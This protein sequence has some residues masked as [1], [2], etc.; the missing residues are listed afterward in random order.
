M[1]QQTSAVYTQN[2]D[3]CFELSLPDFLREHGDSLPS[4]EEMHELQSC[5]VEWAR[6]MCCLHLNSIAPAGGQARGPS[7]LLV[8]LPESVERHIAAAWQRSP[9]LG[10]LLHSLAQALC[11]NALGLAL[12]EV[13]AQGCAPLP[14]LSSEEVLA[15]QEAIAARNGCTAEKGQILRP[16]LSVTNRVYSILTYYPHAGDCECC[17]LREGC[18]RLRH[19]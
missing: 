9:S 6:Q 10:Y 17:A 15:L 13:G 4:D 5:H 7:L 19:S 18:P 11:R 1:E 2:L 3:L 8:Y 12:P 16:N 14:V